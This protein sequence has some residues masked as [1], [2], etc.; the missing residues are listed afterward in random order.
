LEKKEIQELISAYVTHYKEQDSQE[1]WFK[2]LKTFS[3]KNGFAINMKDFKKNSEKY[4]GTVGDVA[5]ILRVAITGRTKT[6]DLYEI[7]KVMGKDTV[8]NRLKRQV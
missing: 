2:D 3:E 4:R 5:M 1:L 6:P 8:L 7:M